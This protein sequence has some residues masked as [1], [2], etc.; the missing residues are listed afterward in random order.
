MLYKEKVM[1]CV[2]MSIEM[3]QAPSFIV[4]ELEYS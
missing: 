1:V 4:L 2:C 3:I